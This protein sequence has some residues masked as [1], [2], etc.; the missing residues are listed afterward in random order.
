MCWVFCRVFHVSVDTD[1]VV[2][3]WTSAAD[4]CEI[5][6]SNIPATDTVDKLT[7]IF[8]SK[9]VTGIANCSVEAIAYDANDS[10]CAV[11][12][13]TT[14]EG[15]LFADFKAIAIASAYCYNSY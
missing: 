3:T 10:T 4:C 5:F 6:V 13:F 14:P 2:N 7:A 15:I 9:R 11:V 1:T 12:K 8:E